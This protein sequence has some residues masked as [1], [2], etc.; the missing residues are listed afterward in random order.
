MIFLEIGKDEGGNIFRAS[1]SSGELAPHQQPPKDCWF[2]GGGWGVWYSNRH[3]LRFGCFLQ[4]P[5]GDR[6]NLQH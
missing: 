3:C 6:E 4:K 2:S 1:L 5:S